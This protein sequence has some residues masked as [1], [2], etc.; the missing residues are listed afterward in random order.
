M[1]TVENPQTESRTAKRLLAPV[2][3]ATVAFLWVG[4]RVRRG[5][6]GLRW[7]QLVYRSS[8]GWD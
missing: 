3:L 4:L 5:I 7:Y 8:T 2:M 6:A 1:H